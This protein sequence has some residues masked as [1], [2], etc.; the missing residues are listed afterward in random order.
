M[1]GNLGEVRYSN[2]EQLEA[3]NLWDQARKLM[4][5]YLEKIGLSYPSPDISNP[6]IHPVKKD[7]FED[8]FD[9][10]CE[11][12]IELLQNDKT[13]HLLQNCHQIPSISNVNPP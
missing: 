4:M 9:F 6:P 8:I 2:G 13:V 10:S 1:L 12:T 5:E 11:A 7:G 3:V